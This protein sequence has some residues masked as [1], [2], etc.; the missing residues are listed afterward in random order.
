MQ[1]SGSEWRRFLKL[2]KQ[3]SETIGTE[4]FS[5]LVN[6]LREVLGAKCVYIGEFVGSKPERV[7][8]LAAFVECKGPDIFEFPLAGSPDAEV[9]AGNPSM[10]GLRGAPEA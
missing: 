7:R 2:A 10:Y 4:F 8:T 1:Q 5:T 6:Q 9:A 3:V